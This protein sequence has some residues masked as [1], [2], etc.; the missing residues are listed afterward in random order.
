[1]RIKAAECYVA[2]ADAPWS[3]IA[4]LPKTRAI[5]RRLGLR[6]HC[7]VDAYGWV[8]RSTWWLHL[9]NYTINGKPHFSQ[10]FPRATQM[11]D[12][13]AAARGDTSVTQRVHKVAHLDYCSGEGL[14]NHS[15]TVTRRRGPIG[16]HKGASYSYQQAHSIHVQSAL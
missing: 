14:L 2:Y 6:V 5:L 11:L 9:N 12:L 8:P 4:R 1:M 15:W 7:M 10:D 16:C 13:Y 3:L